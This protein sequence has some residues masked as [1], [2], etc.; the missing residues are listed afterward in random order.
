MLW[1][2]A[3]R[4]HRLED[5]STEETPL[6]AY[7]PDFPPGMQTD[8]P[9][10]IAAEL[11]LLVEEGSP[12]SLVRCLD[13]IK[14]RNIGETEFGRMMN[15]AA[16]VLLRELYPEIKAPMPLYDPPKTHPYA[17]IIHEAEQGV[18]T[19]P[20]A[21]SRDY[22]QYVL[23]F[24]T[25]LNESRPELLL[26]AVADLE[27]AAELN[28]N[29]VLAPFFL[30][31]IYERSDRLTEANESFGMA[32]R[33]SPECYPAALG[34]ARIHLRR[35]QYGEAIRFL[36]EVLTKSPD[37]NAVKRLLAEGYYQNKDW[38]RADPAVQ[39]ILQRS[40]RDPQFLLMRAHILVEMGQFLQAQTPLDFYA[41]AGDANN[42][43]YQFLRARVQ[44]EG[45]RNRDAALNYLRS[46]LRIAPD[47]EEY[48]V[49][50]ARLLMESPRS[51]DQTE[52]RLLMQ[53]LLALPDPSPIILDLAVQEAINR[54]AWKESLPYLEALLKV[55][56]SA[57]DLY[58]AYTVQQGLGN[59][60]GAL[61]FARELYERDSENDEGAIAFVSALIDTRQWDAA[62]RMIEAKLAI[63]SGGSLKSRYYYLRSRIRND[64]ESM[65]KDLSSSL[66]EDP[67]N[68]DALIA[69]FEVYH[70]RR[71]R[72]RAV[73]YLKQSLAIA[74]SNPRLLRYQSEYANELGSAY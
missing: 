71:D 4:F 45:Y 66:F 62:E 61:A 33:L 16:S 72:R 41:S 26:S 27:A 56:R 73:Y 52:G 14:N 49:Y 32:F 7:P 8:R 18:Y 55:R 2:C 21:F 69:M 67:R 25:Y 11:R 51:E 57:R 43:L 60:A 58:Y 35:G 29:S 59:N 10:G 37:N 19:L 3:G 48:S 30:G 68:L 9:P 44:A 20:P 53:T 64:D 47:V 5:F 54:G 22:L 24:L 23:P 17:K 15:A 40:P 63:I 70:R 42:R 12:P 1:A 36:T 50:A 39:E 13:L 74:P 31:L 34:I 28:S 65:M 38:S 46:L 6:P